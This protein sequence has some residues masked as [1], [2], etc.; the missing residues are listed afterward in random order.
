MEHYI[1]THRLRCFA[2]VM[3]Y[4][5]LQAHITSNGLPDS[6]SGSALVTVTLLDINDNDPVFENPHPDP[7]TL[8]EVKHVLSVSSSYP[9]FFVPDSHNLYIQTTPASTIVYTFYA[10]DADQGT[11]GDITFELISPVRHVNVL[12]HLYLFYPCNQTDQLQETYC[13][14]SL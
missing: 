6:A 8:I 13:F 2:Y 1:F 5:S 14:F 9:Q 12:M 4:C 10:T 3:S 11:N 7:I